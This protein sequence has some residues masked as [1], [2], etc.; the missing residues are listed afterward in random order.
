M[1]LLIFL[2]SLYYYYINFP[3]SKLI[4]YSDKDTSIELDQSASS[5]TLSP[6]KRKNV[7]RSLFLPNIKRVILPPVR[8]SAPKPKSN[9]NSFH[10]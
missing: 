4:F 5:S 8:I 3:T 7:K 6:F 1:L 10:I 9:Q 2:L